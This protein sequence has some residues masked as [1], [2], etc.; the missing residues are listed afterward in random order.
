MY[1]KILDSE[2][3]WICGFMPILTAQKEEFGDG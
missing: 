1:G 2:R 3:E